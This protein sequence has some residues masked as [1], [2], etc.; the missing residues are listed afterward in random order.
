VTVGGY[1]IDNRIYYTSQSITIES[2]RTP[3][4]LQLTI[5]SLTQ[6]LQQLQHSL[7]TNF[8]FSDSPNTGY[9]LNSEVYDLWSDCRGDSAFG[10]GCLAIT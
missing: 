8:F 7:D 2:L 9:R 10:I 3:S 6:K 5:H 4:G 1:W